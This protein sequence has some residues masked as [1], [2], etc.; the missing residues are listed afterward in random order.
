MICVA[1]SLLLKSKTTTIITVH[2]IYRNVDEMPTVNV[3]QDGDER[4]DRIQQHSKWNPS[5]REVVDKALKMLEEKEVPDSNQLE[6][7]NADTN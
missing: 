5:K 3:S 7:T 4:I 1:R 2:H 6:D